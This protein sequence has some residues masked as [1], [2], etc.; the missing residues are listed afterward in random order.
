MSIND[1]ISTSRDYLISPANHRIRDRMPN[2]LKLVGVH[3]NDAN[4]ILNHEEIK[5]E[6]SH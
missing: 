1:E 2:D 5:V 4:N 6:V 3:P